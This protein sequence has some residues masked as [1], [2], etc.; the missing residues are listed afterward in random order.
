MQLLSIMSMKTKYDLKMGHIKKSFSE[1][2]IT[3]KNYQEAFKYIEKL[4]KEIQDS[5]K[6]KLETLL[7]ATDKTELIEDLEM[8]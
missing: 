8:E 6:I 4:N 5:I 7:K 1:E 3:L 2:E